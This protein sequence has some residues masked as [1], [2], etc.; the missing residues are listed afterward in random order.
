MSMQLLYA[1]EYNKRHH[2]FKEVIEIPVIKYITG[3]M[4][5]DL[6]EHIYINGPLTDVEDNIENDEKTHQNET[7]THGDAPTQQVQKQDQHTPQVQELP[8]APNNDEHEQQE[9]AKTLT[10]VVN[11]NAQQ[12]STLLED[13]FHDNIPV[14]EAAVVEGN[15][16]GLEKTGD[17]ITDEFTIPPVD[18]TKTYKRRN[19]HEKRSKQRMLHTINI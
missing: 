11:K 13:L 14:H 4:V 1:H 10:E 2:F 17:P 6:E 12:P 7:Q 15:T 3:I 19:E 9:A 5:D 8:V 18:M 16:I